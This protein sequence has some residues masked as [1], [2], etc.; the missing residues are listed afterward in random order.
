MSTPRTSY[1]ATPHVRA[2]VGAEFISSS[3]HCVPETDSQGP[4]RFALR[5][6][7]DEYL[8]LGSFAEQ[9]IPG[10]ERCGNWAAAHSARSRFKA[11]A[12]E[13]TALTARAFPSVTQAVTR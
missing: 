8:A 4:G 7:A 10:Y 12:R 3:P 2:R 6:L 11:C 13:Y 1:S 5:D 9:A